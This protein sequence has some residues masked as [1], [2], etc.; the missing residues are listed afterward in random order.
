[1][2]VNSNSSP[3]LCCTPVRLV[4]RQRVAGALWPD[5]TDAQALTNLRRELHH[6]REAWP[7]LDSLI[8]TALRT[9][10]WRGEA[11]R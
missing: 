10:A 7:E 4:P 2:R 6:L 5:S 8:D 9:L 11:R 1:V 3:I